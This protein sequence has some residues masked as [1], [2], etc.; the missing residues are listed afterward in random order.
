MKGLILIIITCL[1]LT[2][3]MHEESKK[4]GDGR[5]ETREEQTV[6][7][8]EALLNMLNANNQSLVVLNNDS[9]SY[10]NGRGVSDLLQLLNEDSDRLNGAIV[11]DKMVGK[12][13]A[14]LM[15]AAKV[16]EVHTNLICTSA[17]EVFRTAGIPVFFTE[18]VP[19]ILN[20][21]HSGQCPIDALLNEA[22]S[23]EECVSILN[24]KFQ[25]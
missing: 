10:Y 12:A 23:V 17:L 2:A 24:V 4:L 22:E 19:Q 3:C 16:R 14:T 25:N 6:S 5:Q 21:D 1:T 18:E 13:A 7:Q 9:L 11:A 20:R 8:G 15:V